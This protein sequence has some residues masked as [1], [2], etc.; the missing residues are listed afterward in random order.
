MACSENRQRQAWDA[1]IRVDGKL[2]H[3]GR[4]ASLKTAVRAWDRA[5][6]EA[7]GAAAYQNIPPT[8]E[9]EGEGAVVTSGGQRRDMRGPLDWRSHLAGDRG[10]VRFNEDSRCGQ[11]SAVA[12][13]TNRQAAQSLVKALRAEGWPGAALRTR[14]TVW[15]GVCPD[16]MADGGPAPLD[17]SGLND[18]AG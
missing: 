4:F 10:I 6:R 13:W 18:L 3:L 15:L 16:E 11:Q 7:W 5:A 1:T 2:R 17:F 12:V 9:T 14:R 8:A